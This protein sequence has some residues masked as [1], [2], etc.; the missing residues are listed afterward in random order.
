[1]TTVPTSPDARRARFERVVGDVLV[2]LQRYLRRR[3]PLEVAED[4][5]ADTLL[6]LWRRLDEVPEGEALPWS[7]GVAHRCLANHQRAGRR[8]LRL[9]GRLG[10]HLPLQLASAPP[11]DAAWGGDPELESALASLS[12]DDRELL[13]LWAWE[14]LEP[15]EIALVLGVTPNAV[16]IRLHRARKRLRLA[17]VPG[18]DAP[19][20]DVPDPGHS[21]LGLAEEH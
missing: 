11:A 21:S 7:Y 19:G 1:V 14:Q 18:G 12:I 3:A 2:P 6:V 5:L 20:K 9:V 4:A 8:R 17:V 15:Q 10:S 13:Q 16:S